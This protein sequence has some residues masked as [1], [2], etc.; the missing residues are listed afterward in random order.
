MSH[1]QFK[2]YY[3]NATTFML[4]ENNILLDKIRNL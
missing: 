3:D 2:D 4:N 1:Q